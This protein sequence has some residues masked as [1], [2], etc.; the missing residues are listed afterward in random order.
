[1]RLDPL[2]PGAH[3]LLG[4]AL[5]AVGRFAEAVASWDQWDRVAFRSAEEEAYRATVERAR[6]AAR[7]FANV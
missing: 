6:Q 5:V 2:L 7:V 1:V 4:Y 3:R